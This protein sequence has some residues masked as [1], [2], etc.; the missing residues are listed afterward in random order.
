[1]PTS[2]VTRRSVST[3][4]SGVLLVA[5]SA[6]CFAAMPVFARTMYADG[7][8]PSTLLL[9]RFALAAAFLAPLAGR[10][11]AASRPCGRTLG[12]LVLLGGLYVCQSLS[13]V[14]ALT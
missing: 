1:M 6:L 14:S 11:G 10:R 4:L 3:R 9:L 5:L 12:G 13:Y 8:D 7:G 2:E